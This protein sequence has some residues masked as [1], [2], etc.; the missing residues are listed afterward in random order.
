MHIEAR[1]GIFHMKRQK[2]Y[3][4]IFNPSIFN[5][6]LQKMKF[7]TNIFCSVIVHICICYE[8]R[9]LLQVK[10][11]LKVLPPWQSDTTEGLACSMPSPHCPSA[12]AWDVEEWRQFI[13][14]VHPN[15]L[16]PLMPSIR[17]PKVEWAEF[18]KFWTFRIKKS[19]IA[20]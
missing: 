7:I 13:F 1:C 4:L 6:F 11:Q 12:G 2:N 18:E 19:F 3:F 17:F 8:G 14:Q 9:K 10:L 20:Y 16:L 15:L 5:A